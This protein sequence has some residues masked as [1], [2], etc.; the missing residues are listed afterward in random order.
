LLLIPFVSITR[1][2]STQLERF[3]HC[4]ITAGKRLSNAPTS[5]SNEPR[6]CLGILLD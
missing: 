5:M 6:H 2:V 3:T 1:E 4:R